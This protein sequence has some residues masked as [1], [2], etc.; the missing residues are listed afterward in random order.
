MTKRSDQQIV[1]GRTPA[2]MRQ[3]SRLTVTGKVFQNPLNDRRLLDSGKRSDAVRDHPQL[4]A[5]AAA[6]LDVNSGKRSDAESREHPL[7]AL[8]L[9]LSAA[10]C[11]SPAAASSRLL[12]WLAAAARGPGTTRARSALAGARLA[13]RLPVQPR[14]YGRLRRRHAGLFLAQ[15]L[16]AQ[17]RTQVALTTAQPGR[18]C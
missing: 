10:R 6:G 2:R 12:V 8:R 1:L 11:R 7:Q 3:L 13:F 4:P 17:R 18:D 14:A 16:A 9:R 5:A 15:G